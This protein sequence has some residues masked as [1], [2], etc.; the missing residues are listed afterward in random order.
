MTRGRPKSLRNKVSTTIR[1]DPEIV[2]AFRSGGPG[3]Q[4][5]INEVLR[6]WL[7]SR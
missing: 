3:W 7:A 1:L 2:Q 4:S 6:Q 5:R